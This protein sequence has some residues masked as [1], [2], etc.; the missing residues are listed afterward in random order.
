MSTDTTQR[1]IPRQYDV[2]CFRDF[3][4]D[5]IR[6]RWFLQIEADNL[7]DSDYGRRIALAPDAP[8]AILE[9][10]GGRTHPSGER[11]V[12]LET[13]DGDWYLPSMRIVYVTAAPR[14]RGCE[15]R[16]QS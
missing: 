9:R 13:S 12:V 4:G 1:E 7:R 6:E 8:I 14:S 5:V 15:I 11:V 2:E 16:I 3:V 10:V